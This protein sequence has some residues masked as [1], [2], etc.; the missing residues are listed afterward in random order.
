MKTRTADLLAVLA[1][2]VLAAA[3]F[4]AA[5]G[6]APQG[7]AAGDEAPQW[8]RGLEPA[9]EA[10]AASGKPLLVDLYA[11]W[12]V[13]CKKLEERVFT[14]PEFVRFA[15]DFVLLRVDVEDGDEGTWLQAR[16]GAYGLP[17]LAILDADLVRMGLVQGYADVGSITRRI[18]STVEA[19][20]ATRAEL[21]SRLESEDLE[22]RLEVAEELVGLQDGTAAAAV[23]RR[24]MERDDVSAV[25]RAYM[26]V[27]MAE[28]LRLGRDYGAA[29]RALDEVRRRLA[30]APATA[31]DRARVERAL[32]LATLRLAEELTECQQIAALESFLA[33]RPESSY[34]PRVRDRL[35]HLRHDTADCSG[36]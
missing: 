3:P 14:H 20:E 17:T 2:A 31:E 13:W 24:L 10:A 11:D 5:A 12:C 32:D 9:L 16:L 7:A 1:A 34:V 21:R 23:Y 26:G 36:T 25:E 29:G 8:H 22:T 28:A 27:T 30:A 4:P 19:Y 33:K 15:E 6:A 18:A 35:G